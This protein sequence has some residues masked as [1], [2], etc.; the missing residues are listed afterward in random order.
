MGEGWRRGGGEEDG[1]GGWWGRMGE[2]GGGRGGWGSGMAGDSSR[3]KP[4]D[5]VRGDTSPQLRTKEAAAR[6][7]G[8]CGSQNR[9]VCET[10]PQPLPSTPK[11]KQL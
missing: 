1:G 8:V 10:D 3:K 11:S 5:R 9:Q 4:Q 2:G 7:W 6:P